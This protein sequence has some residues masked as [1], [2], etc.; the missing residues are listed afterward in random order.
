MIG[1]YCRRCTAQ[2]IWTGASTTSPNWSNVDNW[3]PNLPVTDDDLHFGLSTIQTATYDDISTLEVHSITFDAAAVPFSI[4]LENSSTLSVS[5]GGVTNST[6]NT[7]TLEIERNL[8]FTPSETAD[9]ANFTNGATA[10]NL[11]INT[12]G[13]GAV[14]MQATSLDLAGELY[15]TDTSTAATST[16]NNEGALFD[17]GSSVFLPG[18]STQ[19]QGTRDGGD[20]DNHEYGRHRRRRL[21]GHAAISPNVDGRTRD[22]R[23]SGRRRSCDPQFRQRD[24]RHDDFHRQF[25]GGQF[26]NFQ[27]CRRCRL[28]G[29][30]IGS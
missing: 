13:A 22:D 14:S 8:N 11:H 7:E 4:F 27:R 21:G 30:K 16:I 2:D 19:F 23:Q 29:G 10:G 25:L 28:S 18:G 26:A 24:R 3:F 5:G 1:G 15:F 17:G 9:I 12:E 20:I 6:S